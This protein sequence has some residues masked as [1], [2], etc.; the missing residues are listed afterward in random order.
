MPD[1]GR[2]GALPPAPTRLSQ[3]ADLAPLLGVPFSDEQLAAVTA[4]LAPGLIVAAAGSGKTAVMAARVVWLVGTGA[5]QPGQ[6]L[7]LTFTRKAAAELSRRVR[8][9]LAAAGLAP[10]ADAADEE[11]AVA[12]YD[13]FAA[14]L[15]ADWGGWLGR[16][17]AGRLLDDAARFKL[18]SETVAAA[19]GPQPRLSRLAPSSVA[20]A[21]LELDAAMGAN[22]VGEAAVRDWTAA[23]RR[24]LAAAPPARHGGPYLAVQQAL[25]TL[26]ERLELLELRAAYTARKQALGVTEFA[27]QLADAI[28]AERAAPAVRADLARRFAVVLL[29]EYQDTSSAQAI[30][31][32]DLFGPSPAGPGLPVTAVGDPR[33]AIYGWRGASASNLA[34]FGRDFA[35]DGAAVRRFG[36]TVNRRSGRAVLRAAAALAPP[37]AGLGL[38]GEAAQAA[39]EAGPGAVVT[40]GFL[41]W[42]DEVAWIADRIA[43]APGR[44]DTTPW[45]DMAVLAR[46]NADLGAVWQALVE[47]DVPVEIVGLGGLLQVPEVADLVAHLRLIEDPASGPDLVR[48]LT[49]PRWRLGRDDLAR[50]GRRAAE[51]ALSAAAEPVTSA[52]TE[53]V[54]SAAAEPATSTV[55]EPILS[56]VAEPAASLAADVADAAGADALDDAIG[57]AVAGADGPGLAAAL[58]DPGPGVGPRLARRLRA[59]QAELT[60]LARRRR[61]PVG[62]LVE[63][64][65]HVTGLDLELASRPEPQ[66]TARRRQVRAFRDAAADYARGDRTAD[67]AGFLAW[68][69][70]EAEFGLGLA[71]ATASADDSVKLLTVHRAK[72]LEWDVVYLPGLVAAVFPSDRVTANPWRSAAAL[73]HG[74]RADAAAMPR[75]EA[76]SGPARADYAPAQ[77]A[78]QRRAEDRLAYVAVTRAR[79][80]LVGTAH[81]W[82]AGAVRPRGPSPYFDALAAAAAASG[83]RLGGLPPADGAN[84]LDAA[85]ADAAWPAPPDAAQAEAAA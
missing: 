25:Q 64:V 41:T 17:G 26:D 78:D 63:A 82:R 70:A 59:C 39:P 77:R 38:G 29:D 24:D 83:G 21:L 54:L 84:P 35:A 76:A 67:L 79:H 81:R 33:Q 19:V 72:G 30:L 5:V 49:G 47:R 11:P 14:S 58:A 23:R 53:P 6:V 34:D 10:T 61:E 56:T 55:A 48:L 85:G 66:A 31:L 40:A 46:R 22:L 37:T 60:A 12:T 80:V 65:V 69:D 27:D 36:L 20:R 32:R 4:P 8:A 18:A 44:G 43:G 16:D 68:L 2:P 13:A 42:D 75:L 9:A 1:S 51:L 57:R 73:P 74:L 71:R 3:P 62:D 45:R 28:A 7:G 50:L 52:V 15:V